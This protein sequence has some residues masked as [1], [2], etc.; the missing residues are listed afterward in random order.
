MPTDHDTPPGPSPQ[1][2]LNSYA[3]GAFPMDAP[4]HADE[5]VPFY[6][7]DPRAVIP[8]DRFRIPRSVGR[9]LGRVG[10]TIRI[11]TAFAEVCARCAVRTDG[12]WLSPRLISSY[13]QLHELGYAHSVEA[14]DG[15]ALV[16][17]L[18]GIALGGL[19]TA[20]S[21]FRTASDAGNAVIVATGQQLARCE[22]VV[23]DIQTATNH[24]LRF[25]TELIS[26]DE[27][28]TRLRSALRLTRSFVG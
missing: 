25:G 6:E 26:R 13:C 3:H 2:L 22:F 7:S 9:R 8:I 5:L 4:E 27:Y 1:E 16:G 20:E 12:T 14:W 23:W 15:P 17:G 19:F 11:D 10:F 28:R 24:T 21:M 18:F